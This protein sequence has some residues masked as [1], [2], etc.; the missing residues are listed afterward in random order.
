MTIFSGRFS[1]RQLTVIV[2]LAMNFIL[3]STLQAQGSGANLTFFDN[4]K[5][6]D[7]PFHMVIMSDPQF[8]WVCQYCDK[9]GPAPKPYSGSLSNDDH[10]KSIR[11]LIKQLGRD[12]FA[13]IIING[14][15]TANGWGGQS[16]A[17]QG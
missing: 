6:G 7:K 8:D 9:G 13:G 16:F 4:D 3:T 10:A 15:L 5:I 2:M 1:I 17:K 14:D 11:S 12:K